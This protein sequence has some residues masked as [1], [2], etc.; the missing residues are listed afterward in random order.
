M[1][2][3]TNTY[4]PRSR[5]V[6]RE[7][8]YE[9][10]W[11]TPISHLAAEYGVSG[12]YLARVCTSLAVPR[13]P[14][15]YWQKKAVGKASPRPPLPLAKPGD[16]LVWSADTPLA[17]PVT[18]AAR[19][20]VSS[21][22]RDR[23]RKDARHPI[24]RGV[25]PHFRKTRKIDDHEFLRPYKLLL[26]DIVTSETQLP[27]ALDLANALY[28]A[29]ERKG[30][31]VTFAPPDQPLFRAQIEEQEVPGKDR[32]YGRYSYGRI[33]APHRP[34]I[35]YIGEVPIGLALVE[36]SERVTL[37]YFKG[38]YVRY[39]N[40]VVKAASPHHLV[41]S[42]T[43]EYDVPSGRFRLVAYAPRRDVEWSAIWQETPKRG[44]LSMFP[45]IVKELEAV[46]PDLKSKTAEAEATAI[47][48]QREWEEQQE[49]WKRDEDR[50]NADKALAQSREELSEVIRKW[51]AAM[52]IESFFREAEER[53]ADVETDRRQALSSRLDL[54]RSM[55]GSLDPLEF[56]EQWV[57]PDERYRRQYP[58]D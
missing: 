29:F 49:R 30:Y 3:D 38:K 53:L 17:P 14:A 18:P 5:Q 34:T 35:A 39:D 50:R 45:T 21:P 57:A 44:L 23:Q 36:M 7:E 47:R 52:S 15:G 41:H 33:W 40:A 11:S 32:K 31:R 43:T 54:A 42:W 20:S 10:V 1:R 51:S 13:P 25:E 37:R 46:V 48:K 28:D 16:Q 9:K 56:L 26:P 58:D 27:R 24:L 2:H 6:T 8:L 22:S 4:V 12:S 19:S 55:M